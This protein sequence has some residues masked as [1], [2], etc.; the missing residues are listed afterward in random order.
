LT[1]FRKTLDEGDY[2]ISRRLNNSSNRNLY[3][4]MH[5][6][7]KHEKNQNR[8]GIHGNA[9]EVDGSNPF[10]AIGDACERKDRMQP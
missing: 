9:A 3:I 5:V 4:L 2:F 10:P 6:I 8:Y 1:F 7:I